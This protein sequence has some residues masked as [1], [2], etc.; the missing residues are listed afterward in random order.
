[1]KGIGIILSIAALVVAATSLWMAQQPDHIYVVNNRALFEGFEVTKTYEAKLQ[2]IEQSQ[3]ATLDSLDRGIR[4]LQSR[5][6]ADKTNSE[7]EVSLQRSIQQ[8]QQLSSRFRQNTAQA[9]DQFDQN[10]W[11]QIEPLMKR[12]A[13]EKNYPYLLGKGRTDDLYHYPE[14]REV[15]S[16]ALEFLNNNYGSNE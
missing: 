4:A 9:R 6:E 1:M 16:E 13:I 2:Q 8:Y 7:L 14:S 3:V 15:T 10:I 11:E 12:F 5:Y